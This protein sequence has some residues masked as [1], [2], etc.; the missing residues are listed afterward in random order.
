MAAILC[1]TARYVDVH[2][3][4]RTHTYYVRNH[5]YIH[6]RESITA[7]SCLS[8]DGS[9]EGVVR[10]ALIISSSFPYLRGMSRGAPVVSSQNSCAIIYGPISRSRVNF[11][12]MLSKASGRNPWRE[13]PL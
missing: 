5:Q 2:G 3:N 4:E 12:D 13:T 7:R 1:A 11:Y 6:G 10:H 8:L 9:S